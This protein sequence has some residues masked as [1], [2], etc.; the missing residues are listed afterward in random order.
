MVC[1]EI[2]CLVGAFLKLGWRGEPSG[3]AGLGEKRE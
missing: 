1:S 2:K 3:W